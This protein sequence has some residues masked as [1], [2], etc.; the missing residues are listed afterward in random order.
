M[1]FPNVTFACEDE[2]SLKHTKVFHNKN[3]F[4]CYHNNRG[5]CSFGDQCKYRHF[6]DICSRT[7]CRERE[8]N[9]RHPV[10]CRYRDDCKF[11]KTNSCAFKHINMETNK[12]SKDFETNIEVF[13]KE[14]ESLKSEILELTSDINYKKNE[15]QKSK[16]EVHEL[17]VKLTLLNKNKDSEK[18][19]MEEKN[20]LIKEVEMLKKENIALKMKYAKK[21]QIDDEKNAVQLE[22]KD[23]TKITEKIFCEKCCI[24]FSSNKKLE[25]HKSEM[26]K[27]MLTF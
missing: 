23:D 17:T 27:A 8:C 12:A 3:M 22:R 25:K 11:Y 2:I 10:I 18:D 4:Q 26:H 6:K 16:L 9:K 20:D 19:I 5:Y 13:A 21:D 14:I 24:H 1:D 15:L 7:V